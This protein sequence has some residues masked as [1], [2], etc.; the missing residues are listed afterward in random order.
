MV[1]DPEIESVAIFTTDGELLDMAGRSVDYH[2]VRDLATIVNMIAA[3]VGGTPQR[4]EI[5]LGDRK[6]IMI[7]DSPLI[8]VGMVMKRRK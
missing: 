7:V 1:S 3:R 8:R 4:L 6:I 2:W 5:D